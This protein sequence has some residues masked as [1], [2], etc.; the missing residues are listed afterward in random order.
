MPR[1]AEEYPWERALG[2]SVVD[3]GLVEFRVWAPAAQRV[4]V[5]VRGADHELADEGYGVR[6]ARGGRERRRRLL[7]R[8]RRQR[9]AR[10]ALA[11]AARG[12][13]RAVARR[14]P[15]AFAWT[16]GGLARAAR[17]ATLVLYE[18][19]VGTFTRGG[20]VR[21]RR[22]RT[23]AAL[24][25]ARRH[26]DRA[27]AGRRVPRRAAAG[28]TTASTSS[29]RARRPTAARTGSQR[30]VDAAHAAGLAV[31]LDVVYNHVGAVRRAGAARPSARTSPT[32]YETPWGEAIN[33]DDARLRRRPRVGAAERRAAG[34]ATS[35]STA[36]ASTPI[37]A[38]YDDGA[39]HLVARARRPR[40]RRATARALVIAESGL[41]RP[42]GDAPAAQRR[43][44]LRRRLGRRLP[45]RAARAAH[46]RARRATT[47]SSARVG[48]AGQGVPPPARPRRQLLDVPPAA[49]SARRADD[50]AAR[51]LRRLRARTTTRSATAR[52]GD[53]LPRRGAAARRVLH[54]AVTLH[55]DALQGE[56][57]GERAP[58]QFFS[59]HIDEDIADAT[60][61]GRRREFAA[62]AEFAGEEVPDPQDPA[63]FERSKLT[64][65]RR[66]RGLRELYAA[67]LR[68]RRELP[69]GDADAIDFDEHARLAARAP[70]RRSRCVAN[71][72]REPRARAGGRRGRDRARHARTRRSSRGCV[73][74]AARSPER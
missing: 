4:A 53:R 66:A 1:V 73:R 42:E 54:A 59:D 15:G 71:F 62:F 72:A 20:H 10:P 36:C 26:R 3:D 47:R 67:L 52:F 8:A 29:R 17:C 43:L 60:R 16:D 35:T 68:A 13:A 55:A 64:R 27:D 19:H 40:A 18:L 48:A 32:R 38:I 58:F 46:R 28:A 37:H 31:I 30:L 2:A 61:E 45:P 50:V 70:R 7:A 14:R 44:G 23:C 39:E 34:S 24:R 12:A 22:S 5:R 9:A 49:A 11:L 33:F 21:R 57:Y 65:A 6:S 63:T 74:P 51:A 41:Q 25:R 56:E 69:P